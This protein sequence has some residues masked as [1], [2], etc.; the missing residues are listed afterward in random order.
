MLLLTGVT[1]IRDDTSLLIRLVNVQTRQNK[2]IHDDSIN[3]VQSL[4]HDLL[5]TM[6]QHRDSAL[7][8]HDMSFRKIGDQLANLAQRC[9]AHEKSERILESLYCEEVHSRELG[10]SD[11]V[12]CTFDW[13]FNA[14]CSGT[15]LDCGCSCTGNVDTTSEYR[16][17]NHK[18]SL[19]C[20]CNG[21]AR[22]QKHLLDWLENKTS[23]PF[24][25][26]GKPGSGKST[27][28]KFVA[29]HEQTRLA[30]A[31]WAG[32]KK[33]LVARFYFWSSG[34]PLQ[35]SQEGLLRCLLYQILSQAPEMI[36]I[37]VSRRWQA[38]GNSPRTTEPW[39]RKEISDAFSGIVNGNQLNLKICFFVDGL[40]EYGGSDLANGESDLELVCELKKLASSPYIKLCLSSRPRNVFQ[41]HLVSDE[42]RHITLQNHTSKDIE[43]FVKLRIERVRQLINIDPSDLEKLQSM[44]AKRS[45]GVFLW[46]VLVVR[47]LLDGLEPPFSMLEMEERLSSLPESLDGFFQR[48][49]N[50]V[51]RQYRRF[52]AR[53]LLASIRGYGPNLE[54]VYFLWLLDRTDVYSRKTTRDQ[55]P[56]SHVIPGSW[57]SDMCSRIQNTC[58]DFLDT[59]NNAIEPRVVHTHRSVADFLKLPEVKSQLLRY[60]DWQES[61]ISLALCKAF[62]S[63]CEQG[64][65]TVGQRQY[66]LRLRLHVFM[67]DA[68]QYEGDSGQS[69]ADLI[70]RLDTVLRSRP[71]AIQE[72]CL[73]HWVCA[74]LRPCHSSWAIPEAQ[75]LLFWATIYGLYIFVEQ[76]IASL[77]PHAAVTTLNDLLRTFVLGCYHIE[78]ILFAD[79]TRRSMF[80]VVTFLCRKGANPNHI[81]RRTTVTTADHEMMTLTWTT[82]ELYLQ[83]GPIQPIHAED[84]FGDSRVTGDRYCVMDSLIEGG[85]DL[86]CKLP[87]GCTSVQQAIE[88]RLKKDYFKKRVGNDSD[89]GKGFLERKRRAFKLC[90]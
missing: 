40:D 43:H 79:L 52:T 22:H 29:S 21:L 25:V 85:A 67:A 14:W 38:A 44:I 18:G 7:Q 24:I 6:Q 59:D 15:R 89:K 23:E 68:A 32:D 8:S 60:A 87:M 27:F 5:T 83:Q 17:F 49:L 37:A 48:I 45:S 51:H 3:A 20:P 12:D 39:T 55:Y 1:Q 41:N 72:D 2:H 63:N 82:W 58:G 76:T 86:E 84:Y 34:S 10:V 90:L 71:L 73:T 13:A 70:Y 62:V 77:T 80:D 54:T 65:N 81:V 4:K 9:T 57:R 33:L 47:D 50:K 88:G 16:C 36:P 69:C 30:L 66:S 56:H 78:E 74:L 64:I 28:M 26:T 46:V 19:Q 61:D 35:R 42:S 75:A 11:A 53:V 31:D